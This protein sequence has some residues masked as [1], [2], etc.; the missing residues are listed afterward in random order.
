VQ[1][2]NHFQKNG[3][4]IMTSSSRPKLTSIDAKK[5]DGVVEAVHR[6]PN[7]QVAEVRFY[8]RRG[9]TWSDHMLLSRDALIQRLKKGK[10]FGL[11]ERKEYLGGTFRVSS[12]IKVDAVDGKERLITDHSLDQNIELKDAPLF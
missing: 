11:G 7:G 9:P 8:E 3:T 12:L 6:G 2:T 10:K 1:I 5:L 4:P